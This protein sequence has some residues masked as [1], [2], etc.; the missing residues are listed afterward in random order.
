MA[1]EG[2]GS[3]RLF[4]V[5]RRKAICGGDNSENGEKSV[6]NRIV[7]KEEMGGVRKDNCRC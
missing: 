4:A 7:L 6:N 5:S 3:P 1:E 2:G